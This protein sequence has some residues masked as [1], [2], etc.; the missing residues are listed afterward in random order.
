MGHE[1][2]L[3]KDSSPFHLYDCCVISLLSCL[4]DQLGEGGILQ[5]FAKEICPR[6]T[7]PLCLD[8]ISFAQELQVD[9][10]PA[11]CKNYMFYGYFWSERMCSSHVEIAL[12]FP[13]AM[14]DL[15]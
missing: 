11:L 8:P 1:E 6:A 12:T 14:Q 15:T 9:E 4:L 7:S 2:R 13:R 3:T 5:I 10:I